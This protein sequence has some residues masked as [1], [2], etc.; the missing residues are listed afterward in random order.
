VVPVLEVEGGTVPVLILCQEIR[1][2]QGGYIV[3][4][5]WPY[6]PEMPY[7]EV[8]CRTLEEVFELLKSADATK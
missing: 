2:V 4:I 1:R 3:E 7:G 8:V 6:G 5:R